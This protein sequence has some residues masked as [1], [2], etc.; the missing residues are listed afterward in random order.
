MTLEI[1]DTGG[2]S[3]LMGLASWAGVEGEKEDDSGAEKTQKVGGRLVHERTSKTGG[4]NEFGIVLGDRF[5][6]S[7]KGHGVGLAELKAAMS[8]LDLAKLEAM[9]DVGVQK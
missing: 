9:K 2:V 6:V 8:A 4:T 3:G 1:S 7:A 5:V